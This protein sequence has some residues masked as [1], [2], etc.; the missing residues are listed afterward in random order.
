MYVLSVKTEFCAAHAIVLR[1]EREPVHGH[2]FV[3]RVEVAGP[4]LDDEGL[5]CDFHAV[6][7]ALLAVVGPFTNR[8]LNDTPP[9]TTINPTA[10]RLAEHIGTAVAAR[11]RGDLPRGV[12]VVRASVTEAPGCEATFVLRK[13]EEP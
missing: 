13:D 8:N 12:R 9:F 1:G 4:Q 11:L 5:L 2:N 7:Q 3:C 10:E 6:E